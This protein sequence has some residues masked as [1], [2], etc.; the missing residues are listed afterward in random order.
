MKSL[1]VKLNLVIVI[2]LCVFSCGKDDDNPMGNPESTPDPDPISELSISNLEATIPENPDNNDIIAPFIVTQENLSDPLAF[3]L[4]SVDPTGA[5]TINSQGQ[6]LVADVAAFDF[7]TRTTI[8]GE[9]QLSSGSLTDTATFTITIEDVLEADPMLSISNLEATIPENPNSNDIIAPFTVTQENLSEPLVFELLSLDPTGAVTVNDQGQLLVADIAAFDFETRTTISGEVQLSSGTLTDTAT[10]T[11][12]IEDVQ[13][14]APANGV[15]FITSWEV[16]T[17]ELTVELPL[18]SGS[19]YNFRVD[20]GDGSAEGIVT[21]DNDPDAEH[22]YSSAG[23]KT[24]TIT[25]TLTGFS[26]ERNPTSSN[27]FIDVAQWGDMRLGNA[28]GYFQNCTNL[29]GFTATDAPILTEVTNMRSMFKN[30]TVFN[31]DLSMWNVSN[32]NTMVSMF[33]GASAFNTDISMWEVSNVTLMTDMF[34][35]AIA[36]NSDISMWEVSNVTNMSSMFEGA[37]AFNADISNWNVSKVTNMSSMFRDATAFNTDM[38]NWDTSN[39]ANMGAMFSSM[40]NVSKVTLM[41]NMFKDAIVFNV[42]IS[43]W[44]VST[45]SEISYMFNN[46]SMFN[47]DLSGWETIGVFSCNDFSTGSALEAAHLPTQGNCF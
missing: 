30:A 24:V 29:T 14:D 1:V 43:M 19:E 35:N 9:V 33:E 15:P 5:V 12:T 2:L 41:T 37:T 44:D 23:I 13:E 21:S 4:L 11:I 22:T 28:G 17:D 26:F 45:V 25:G 39:V 3:E 46:A 6:L 38:P 7:E 16:T 42:D 10:F 47:Q 8:S 32:A 18:H 36:F 27:L 40:W 20:W 34:H 31:D